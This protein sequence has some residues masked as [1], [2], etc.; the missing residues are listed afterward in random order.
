MTA[1]TRSLVSGA[2]SARPLITFDTV[3]AETP[4]SAAMR[5]IVDWRRGP[6]RGA[7]GSEVMTGV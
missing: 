4:A 1:S 6:T 7:V 5:A 2:T 3:G